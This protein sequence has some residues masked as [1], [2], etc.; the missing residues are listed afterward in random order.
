MRSTVHLARLV[1]AD[2]AAR[3]HG[4]VLLTASIV[5]VMPGPHQ[6]A[7]NAS[8]AFV[9]NFGLGL[10]HELRESGVTVTV[11]EPGP[12]ETPIFARAGQLDTL[13]GSR[14]HKDDPETVAQQ[15]FDAVMAG[16]ETVVAGSLTS[17]AVHFAARLLPDTIV[18]H[19]NAGARATALTDARAVTRRCRRGRG[20]RP[21]P[22]RRDRSRCRS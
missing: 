11:L 14:V 13:L 15:A 7:Y 17:K 18:A 12:T 10:R 8:K 20:R 21:R 19:L 5:D 2:M 1:T 3:G 16:R 6:A 9:T 4:R 22:R